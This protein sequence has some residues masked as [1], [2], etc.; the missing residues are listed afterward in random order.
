MMVQ[1]GDR[2]FGAPTRKAI[3]EGGK[4]MFPR[5]GR[6]ALLRACCARPRPRNSVTSGGADLRV[7]TQNWRADTACTG[8]QSATRGERGG[9]EGQALRGQGAGARTTLRMTRSEPCCGVQQV[10]RLVERQEAVAT[11]GD[12]VAPGQVGPRGATKLALFAG[13]RLML[14]MGGP[15]GALVAPLPQCR[16]EHHLD[17]EI[18]EAC[19][20]LRGRMRFCTTSQ[21]ASLHVEPMFHPEPARRRGGNR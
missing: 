20:S 7:D 6:L 12:D 2:M 14:I 19:L 15:R 8:R 5:R 10:G 17:D 1:E 11:P 18:F 3:R 13:R 4:R 16:S 9:G 21:A